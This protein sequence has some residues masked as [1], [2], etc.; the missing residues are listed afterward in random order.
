[1]L[2]RLVEN[3]L[4]DTHF[5]HFTSTSDQDA[6]LTSLGPWLLPIRRVLRCRGNEG[7]NGPQARVLVRYLS[8][9][10][11][12][13][14]VLHK[15]GYDTDGV[16]KH[17]GQQD[18]ATHRANDCVFGGDRSPWVPGSSFPHVQFRAHH[19]DVRKGWFCPPVAV[20]EQPEGLRVTW[21]AGN[22]CG[23]TLVGDQAKNLLI[24]A[25]RQIAVRHQDGTLIR[26]PQGAHA[27]AY[28]DGS[29]F[30]V[31]EGPLA[32]AAGDAVLALDGLAWMSPC[33]L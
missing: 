11:V 2:D 4:K 19:D 12:T 5:S 13:G 8:G 9:G 6:N 30:N 23:E 29:A 14:S 25:C 26:G 15:W 22:G 17:C 27:V 7:L 10:L 16:C 31:R 1:M 33:S 24:D 18:T 28:T 20:Y 32:S 21:R 3:V